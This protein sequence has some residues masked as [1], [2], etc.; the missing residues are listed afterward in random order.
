MI[1]LLSGP[2][3]PRAQIAQDIAKFAGRNPSFWAY[4]G[5]YDWVA[6]IQLY[7]TMRDL[8]KDWPRHCQD[9][10]QLAGKQSLPDQTSTRHHA[11][12]DALWSRQAWLTVAPS[13]DNDV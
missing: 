4:Y 9:L 10:K 7:G 2:K 12:S 3:T 5:A 8:P 1:S 6:L 11:L 13:P